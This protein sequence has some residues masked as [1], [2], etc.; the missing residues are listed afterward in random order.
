MARYLKEEKFPPKP[1]IRICLNVDLTEAEIDL[2]VNTL[3][4]AVDAVDA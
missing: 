2:V 3:Q 4:S 1:S